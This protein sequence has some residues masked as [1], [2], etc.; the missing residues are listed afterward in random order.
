MT[1]TQ[2]YDEANA[3]P[4][5][6]ALG[7]EWLPERAGG[8]NRYTWGLAH[9]FA[10]ERVEQRWVVVGDPARCATDGV[11]VRA[12]A[13]ASAGLRRRW[14]AI[15]S[16]VAACGP[17]RPSLIATHFALYAWPAV[18]VLRDVPHVVHFHGPWADE[19]SAEG[20]RWF[21]VAAKRFLEKRVY[22]TA[23]R[24]VVL[25][26]AFR[27][28]LVE[29]YGADPAL[30]RVVPGGVDVAR[31]ATSATRTAARERLGLP[32]NRP[33]V[34]CVRRLA[35][36]MGIDVLL[37]AMAEVVKSEPSVMLC[38]AGT[39]PL[40]DHLA[41]RV[42]ALGIDRNV[43]LMGFVPDDD[44]PTLYRAADLSVVPSQAL[45]GFGLI[46]IESLAAGTPVLVTPVG[47][48]PEA[49]G[50]LSPTLI[51]EDASARA[52]AAGLRG[53]LGGSR[54]LPTDDECRR[55]AREGFDWPVIAR[56]VLD[57]YREVAQ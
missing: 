54:G 4:R 35:H 6:L 51:L 17:W 1:R 57:V 31:F 52:I 55:Y 28:V 21:A 29:R 24:F 26:D 23:D 48:L 19:S 5:L 53:A 11:D 33:L 39:G 13:P 44:L 41:S 49:V 20:G 22:R 16:E 27:K 36:R 8:L 30:V 18:G 42:E 43:R 7:A 37:E 3:P 10:T 15:R 38:V 2:P 40:R 46:T 9:A 32:I 45:E 12:V 14:G 47:G 50:G 34:V 56:R 25:S